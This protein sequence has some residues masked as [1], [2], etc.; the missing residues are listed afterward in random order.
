M[1]T[2]E[3]W[4]RCKAAG[5]TEAG[6]AGLMGNIKAESNFKERALENA[7]KNF[8]DVDGDEFTALV[9]NDVVK[10]E[11]LTGGYGLAQW[12][13]DS[14]QS[15]LENY[16]KARGKSIGDADTQTSFLLYEIK[17]NYKTVYDV[18]CTTT[19]VKEASNLV[20]TKYE[21][22]ADQSETVQEYRARLSQEFFTMYAHCKYRVQ[23]GAYV[24]KENA[25]N[26]LLKLKRLGYSDAFITEVKE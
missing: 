17:R 15:A 6:T 20:L 3:F 25:E 2:K 16:C 19:D 13:W 21:Q 5:L 8:K 10:L 14:R 11:E 22:P 1:N 18:L 7:R 24:F 23:V 9:D 12:T 4:D 26:A